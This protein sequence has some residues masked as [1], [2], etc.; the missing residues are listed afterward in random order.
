MTVGW[1][2]KCFKQ[3]SV[4][5]RTDGYHWNGCLGERHPVFSDGNAVNVCRAKVPS[6]LAY[7][8][9]RSDSICYVGLDSRIVDYLL[10]SKNRPAPYAVFNAV[11]L[12]DFFTAAMWARLI[13][14]CWT[15]RALEPEWSPSIRIDC[16]LALSEEWIAVADR[17]R[18]WDGINTQVFVTVQ[19]HLLF[20]LLRLPTLHTSTPIFVFIHHLNS[21]LSTF[22]LSVSKSSIKNLV[23]VKIC[24]I[25]WN[26]E[27]VE[28]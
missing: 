9:T 7:S 19:F 20:P 14:Q 16:W 15:I 5:H 13:N 11:F 17:T 28:L 10:I 4:F 2:W 25:I 26:L 12:A 27:L 18:C 24:L 3:R 21:M 22:M 23:W 6:Y 1:W 8:E